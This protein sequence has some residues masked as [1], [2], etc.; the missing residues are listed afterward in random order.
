MTL[1][2]SPTKQTPSSRPHL[3]IW[4]K[5][6]SRSES[7][8]CWGAYSP[9]LFG[10][11]ARDSPGSPPPLTLGRVLSSFAGEG[12]TPSG[13]GT[14]QDSSF[15]FLRRR[16]TSPAV[17]A[18]PVIKGAS[19]AALGIPE[20]ALSAGTGPHDRPGT[21]P[22]SR[23]VGDAGR[24]VAIGIALSTPARGARQRRERKARETRCAP[25]EHTR[26][27][28]HRAAS[29]SQQRPH[30]SAPSR[31]APQKPYLPPCRAQPCL[32]L[33]RSAPLNLGGA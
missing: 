26:P 22:R 11:L 28:P 15:D 8:G 12:C 31:A 16:V 29:P 27:F 3:S 23:G 9:L 33:A 2:N 6:P 24:G 30:S 32:S 1:A 17:P 10:S 7:R 14:C 13:C 4:G 5:N 18:P 21:L 25:S 19:P 20:A